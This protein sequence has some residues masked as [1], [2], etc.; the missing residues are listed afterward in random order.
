MHLAQPGAGHVRVN[1]RRVDAGVPEEFL[2]HPQV[3]A[4]LQQVSGEA[5]SEHVRRDV[6][7]DSAATDPALDAGPERGLGERRSALGEEDIC[8][9]AR[10]HQLGASRFKITIQRRDGGAANGHDAFLVTL[11]DHVYE[12]GLEVKLLE[13]QTPQLG[14]P[15]A[16]RV[17][18][19]QDSLITKRRGRGGIL[20][21]EQ[22]VDLPGRQRLGQ[23]LPAAGQ[24]KVLG[25]IQRQQLFILGETIKR[26]QRRDL[27]I[28]TLRA[29]ALGR[30][31]DGARELPGA[32]VLEE[33]LQVTEFDCPPVGES[34]LPRPGR[35]LAQQGGV[36]SL[37]VLRLTA[38][39]PEVDQEIFDEWFHG[40]IDSPL[41]A[42]EKWMFNAVGLCSTSRMD[43]LLKLLRDN[44]AL[45][46][47]Q[48]ARM[49]NLSET[50]VV[51]KT[52]AYERDQ[53]I[54]GYRAILNEEKLA[55][56]RV[57]AAIEVK[58]TPERD[59]GFNRVAERIA[60]YDEVRSCFLMS[61]GYDLLVIV[62]GGNLHDVAMFVAEKLAT[63]Q[64]VV[65]TATHF[66]LK[67]Y[68]DHGVLMKAERNEE[69]LAVAP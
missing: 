59:G 51:A 53:V 4:M 25:H 31:L 47:A 68:K 8:R 26:A 39:V 13:P 41:P 27:Q 5:V 32:F 40:S 23:A 33:L 62:E 29:Q 37:G 18:E 35:E 56:D 49:L 61:G 16:R 12:A 9:R 69:R 50:E 45:A 57:R 64:G 11:A 67:P 66:M 30:V 28:N 65:S 63:I 48:L 34:L 7:T 52:K 15:Q 19:F 46:P 20:G 58:L 60:K 43:S 42:T 2:N 3:G 17:G 36:G 38:F 1:L 14:E 10:R 54:L 21:L 6:S 22:A 24:R 44:S 55:L